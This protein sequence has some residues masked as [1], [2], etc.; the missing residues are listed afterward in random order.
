M[1]QARL[2]RSLLCLALLAVLCCAPLGMTHASEDSPRVHMVYMGGNDCKPCVN[3][4]AVEFPNLQ[5]TESYKAIKFSYVVKSIKSP[6]PPAFLLPDEVKPYKMQLDEAS[7]GL[8]GSPQVAIIV[9]D[10]VFD[11]YF[12]SYRSAADVERMLV[13]LRDNT[14]Y[15]FKPCIK[16]K[17]NFACDVHGPRFVSP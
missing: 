2:F 15:P 12:G 10:K 3:W 8:A 1:K 16:M 4:R 5:Q 17:A 9:N 6:V 7:N 11:Y 13:A 14:R